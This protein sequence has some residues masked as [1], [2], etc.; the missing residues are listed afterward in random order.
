M[1]LWL[2]PA[3]GLGE[4]YVLVVTWSALA[5][6]SGPLSAIVLVLTLLL[7]AVGI[8]LVV[9]SRS[10][11]AAAAQ[12]MAATQE[13]APPAD[14]LLDIL[15]TVAAAGLLAWPGFLSD[16]LAL[17]LLV[18]WFRPFFRRRLGSWLLRAARSGALKVHFSGSVSINPGAG[19]PGSPFTDGRPV[20]AVDA[21]PTE[22]KGPRPP[23]YL[24]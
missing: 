13:G 8:G 5:R 23:T 22:E 2:V 3:F 1:G 21:T 16:G 12:L 10:G 9:L 24:P 20:I 6:T 17:L 14:A 15:L 7:G 18:P 4:L 11:V 19:R